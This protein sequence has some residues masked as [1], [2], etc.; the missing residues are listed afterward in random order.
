MK[1]KLR[2]WLIFTVIMACCN[3]TL[4]VMA[5]IA[6]ITGD[7]GLSATSTLTLRVVIPRYLALSLDTVS[8][9]TENLSL[10]WSIDGDSQMS[11]IAES[12]TEDSD[13]VMDLRSNAGQIS[14]TA[15]GHTGS[16]SSAATVP[17]EQDAI[18]D[19]PLPAV[20][21]GALPGPVLPVGNSTHLKAI[22]PPQHRQGKVFTTA[23]DRHA[24]TYTAA[25]P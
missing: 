15:T 21:G 3:A 8:A 12:A 25:S 1:I 4:P 22:W 11:G 10:A 13:T 18:A 7:N 14:I 5:E 19:I 9:S 16:N 20:A 23:S 2:Q 24:I 17:R 6:T